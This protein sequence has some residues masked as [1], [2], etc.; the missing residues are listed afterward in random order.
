MLLACVLGIQG[1][2]CIST[3]GDGSLMGTRCQ[4]GWI[5]KCCAQELLVVNAG[6][7]L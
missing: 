6:L 7:A 5:I 2:S 4:V 1:T 3:S